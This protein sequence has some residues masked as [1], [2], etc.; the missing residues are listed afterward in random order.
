MNIKPPRGAVKRR[1]YLGRGTGTGRGTTSGK[2]TKGQKSRAGY[3]RKIG[4]EGGQMPLVRRIPKRGFNNSTFEKRYQIIN[5]SELNRYKNGQKVDYG[6]L[7][8]DR[9]VNRKGQWVKLLAKGELHKKLTITV[10]KASKKAQ[11]AVKAAGGEIRLVIEP[12]GEPYGKK[13]PD[14]RKPNSKKPNGKKPPDDKK[15][16]EEQG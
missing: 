3:K 11:E 1:K 13:P 9:L 12:Y 14:G 15:S 5:L 7:L 4:F 16:M 6:M 8:K 10:H 2:G